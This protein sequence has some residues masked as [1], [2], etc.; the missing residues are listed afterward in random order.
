[1][2]HSRE[3]I[4]HGRSAPDAER[5]K[6]VAR[7]DRK[8]RRAQQ[9][10][11]DVAWRPYSAVC[12]PIEYQR[13]AT[14]ASSMA[15]IDFDVAPPAEEVAAA[16]VAVS[17]TTKP[18][19]DKK[20]KKEKKERRKSGE[21]SKKRK[22]RDDEPAADGGK[23]EAE[24]PTEAVAAAG[25]DDDEERPLSHK[26]KRLAKKRKLAAEQAGED[27]EAVAVPAHKA[28]KPTAAPN[29]IGNTLV[30]NTPARSA[31]GVWIGNMNFATHPRELLAW[32]ADRGLKDVTRINMP[33]GKR[34]HENNRG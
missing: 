23:E 20:D 24:A 33:G 14:V 16:A 15:D 3:V 28:A 8:S 32:M 30:G 26:E 31:H 5:S 21:S 34:Q 6:K 10:K 12:A 1:M 4:G 19:K 17:E 2:R 27:P 11:V 25:G 13:A 18:K 7:N 9:A 29:S 22:S